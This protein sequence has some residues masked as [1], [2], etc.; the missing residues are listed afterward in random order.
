L[1][2]EI[3]CLS[4]SIQDILTTFGTSL[5]LKLLENAAAAFEGI[6]FWPNSISVIM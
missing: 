5:N 1:A 2:L 4:Q 3:L 6:M